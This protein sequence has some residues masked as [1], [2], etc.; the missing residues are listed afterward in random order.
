M[1]IRE[2]FNHLTTTQL[3]LHTISKVERCLTTEAYVHGLFEDIQ[4]QSLESL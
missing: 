1:K 2:Q 4:D 3:E